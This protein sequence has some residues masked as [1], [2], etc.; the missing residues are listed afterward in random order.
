KCFCRLF[1]VFEIPVVNE[2]QV[3]VQKPVI[4][5]PFNSPFQKSYSLL[6]MLRT[7]RALLREENSTKSISVDQLRIQSSRNVD[8]GF[9]Q[10]ITFLI[11]EPLST[12]VLYRPHPI[13]ISQYPF[14][15]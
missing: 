15:L 7:N 9:Q 8:K 11:P 13:D 14:V 10:I 2:S 6:R 12:I 3:S 4:R 5:V 1:I